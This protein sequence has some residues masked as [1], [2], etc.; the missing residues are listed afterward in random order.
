MNSRAQDINSTLA[1]L[2]LD[3]SVVTFFWNV[4]VSVLCDP[5]LLQE[6]AGFIQALDRLV[7]ERNRFN[8]GAGDLHRVL[9]K[10]LNLAAVLEAMAA[11]HPHRRTGLVTL[12]QTI[13]ACVKWA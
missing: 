2:G 12:G 11:R 7:A 1:D 4:L 13:S 3:E 6:K 10:A 5:V 9:D 8:R